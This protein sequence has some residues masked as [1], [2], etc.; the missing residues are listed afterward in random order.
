MRST[1][2]AASWLATCPAQH[3][4]SSSSSSDLCFH[5]AALSQLCPAN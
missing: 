4:S 1:T 5:A 3:T 2:T